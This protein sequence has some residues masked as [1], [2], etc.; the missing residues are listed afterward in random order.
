MYMYSIVVLVTNATLDV[1]ELLACTAKPSGPEYV[2]T[3][4]YTRSAS[5]TKTAHNAHFALINVI[6]S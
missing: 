4:Y 6:K 1:K 2:K 5:V 3:N